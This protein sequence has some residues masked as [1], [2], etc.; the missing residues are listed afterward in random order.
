[1]H[2]L[3]AEKDFVE[4]VGMLASKMIVQ[5]ESYDQAILNSGAFGAAKWRS[6]W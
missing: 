4:S 1:M 2:A 3:N 5:S 6:S